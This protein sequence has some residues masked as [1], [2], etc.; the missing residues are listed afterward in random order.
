MIAP[1]DLMAISFFL[2]VF[3]CYSW[4]VDY[5]PLRRRTMSYAMNKARVQW[6]ETLLERPLRMID[7]QIIMGLQNGIAF[8]ASTSLLGVGAGFS[9]FNSRDKILAVLNDEASPIHQTAMEWN[10]KVVGLI[11]IFAYAFF[12]FG[13]SYRLFNYASIM[14]G[15]L[16]LGEQQP[17]GKLTVSEEARRAAHRAAQMN[18]VAAQQF[19]R[20][21]RIIFFSLG[22]LGWF[23]GPWLLIAGTIGVTGLLAFRQFLSPPAEVAAALVKDELATCVDVKEY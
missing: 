7:T 14:V 22:Y 5:S 1:L 4:I 17:G 19:N 16:P 3:L 9:L 23:G 2:T 21:L 15:A 13:W 8:F 10:V 12:K 11:I 20:G 6:M 18:I